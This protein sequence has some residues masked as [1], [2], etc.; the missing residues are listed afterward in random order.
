[1]RMRMGKNIIGCSVV[2][3]IVINQGDPPSNWRGVTSNSC[4][5]TFSPSDGSFTLR[6]LA[7]RKMAPAAM[8]W[9][10]NC[11][12]RDVRSLHGTFQVQ[13]VNEERP[14][15]SRIYKLRSCIPIIDEIPCNLSKSILCYFKFLYRLDKGFIRMQ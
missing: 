7:A 11:K 12:Q 1:M 3:H 14:K 15:I 4:H 10:L 5:Q 13:E 8:W 9:G 6:N 2:S